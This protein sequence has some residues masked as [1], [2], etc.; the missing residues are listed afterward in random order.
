MKQSKISQKLYNYRLDLIV[1]DYKTHAYHYFSVLGVM[2][3]N[4]QR[5]PHC[6]AIHDI[7]Y[8]YIYLLLKK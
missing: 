4:Y 2:N 3:N 6:I 7:I 5:M 1:G 8:D